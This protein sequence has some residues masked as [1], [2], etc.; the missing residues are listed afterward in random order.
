MF[1]NIEFEYRTGKKVRL[2]QLLINKDQLMDL[3]M[4][5]I[6]GTTRV[7]PGIEFFKLSEGNILAIKRIFDNA[8]FGCYN[9]DKLWASLMNQ[10]DREA[11]QIIRKLKIIAGNAD[12]EYM[13][14]GYLW[15]ICQLPLTVKF[16]SSVAEFLKASQKMS[17]LCFYM[18]NKGS[19]SDVLFAF[20][21]RYYLISRVQPKRVKKR[22][23]AKPKSGKWDDFEHW[24]EFRRLMRI[25]VKHFKKTYTFSTSRK[26][27][28]ETTVK[29]ITTAFDLADQ[30]FTEL[31]EQF[32]EKQLEM[33]ATIR[34]N[35]KISRFIGCIFYYDIMELHAFT[36]PT[37][38]SF[39]Y[40]SP[41]S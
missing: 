10:N 22:K 25:I 19:Y 27:G 17:Q 34:E 24:M 23:I 2:K 1:D 38:R 8:P 15:E 4:Y 14:R 29:S 6:C 32:S 30:L 3:E 40:K 20:M 16:T 21:I 35:T 37:K 26:K 7:I 39:H 36:I 13:K 18:Y 11:G 9:F 33:I 31:I 12:E 41:F 28:E 5:K